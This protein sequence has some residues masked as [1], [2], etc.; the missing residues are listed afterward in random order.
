[1]VAR[2]E[3]LTGMAAAAAAWP[4]AAIGQGEDPSV[5]RVKALYDSLQSAMASG[6]AS[7]PK[8][9]MAAL[10]EPV[11]SSFDIPNMTRIAVGPRWSSIPPAKREA[12]QE[13][14]GRYFVATYANR[15]G[16]AAGG[17][18]EVMP[19]SERRA[20]G[21]LVR[22]RV[23][24][25]HGKATPVDYLVNPD[26]KIVDVYL[27]GTISELASHRSE[28]DAA[29]KAGGPDALEANLRKRAD[30]LSGGS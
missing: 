10:S 29:L 17:R 13:A 19:K 7:D 14:F 26:G 24:D 4:V 9:R 12:L 27:K 23:I 5:S 28:F 11:M 6:Q 8:Q 2:R 16:Q 21:R 20:G 3:F 1:M 30:A 25:A 18:F 15:L 22:T